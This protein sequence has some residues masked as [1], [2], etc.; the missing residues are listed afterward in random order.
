TWRGFG[1]RGRAVREAW[2]A[3]LAATSE[4]TRAAW[5]ACHA[6]PSAADLAPTLEAFCT[7]AIG[8]APKWATRK[9]SQEAIG[10][11][12]A[13]V[14]QLV[15]GSADLTGSNLTRFPEAQ[16]I[17]AGDFA[18]RYLHFGVR[19][20]G[21]AAALNG[22]TLH[23]GFIGYGGTFLCFT[24]YA[25]PAIRLS[26]LM[27]LG[28]VYVMT[29]DSIGQGEDG[30]TH[31]PIEHLASLRAMPNLLLMR[32]ADAVETAECWAVALADGGR[33]AVLVLS[34]QNLPTLRSGSYG[35]NLSARGAYVLAEADGERAVTILA[36]GSEV[37]I[38]LAAQAKLAERGVAAAVVSMPCWELL[39]EQDEAY[40]A[41]VLG[42]APRVAVEAASP[43]GWTR[44]VAREADVVGMPGFGA[45]APGPDLYQHFG[46]TAD[47]VADRAQAVIARG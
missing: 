3:R 19:E 38:A 26:A 45:S 41:A 18:G 10:A 31:Q 33:P 29:H 25:R 44:Y 28:V 40:R 36:T 46:I 42:T 43:F 9:A 24:D 27:G 13:A 1:E 14:P 2:D 23:G 4:D 39:E 35:E 21:M 37:E 30:P 22:L 5:S 47:A 7:K 6:R 20:H 11:F 15:G 16:V 8:D 12:A 34:R 17:N 32:P